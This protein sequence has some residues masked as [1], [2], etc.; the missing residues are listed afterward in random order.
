MKWLRTESGCLRAIELSDAKLD[1][2][3]SVMFFQDNV[4]AT[5]AEITRLLVGIVKGDLFD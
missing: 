1:L 5:H 3:A 4:T 2:A